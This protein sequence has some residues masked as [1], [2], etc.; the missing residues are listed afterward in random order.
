VLVVDDN[1][2]GAEMLAMF[3][4]L[5][6][7]VART[8]F[9]GKSAIAVARE[10]Q[11]EVVFLDIGLPD[12]TGYEVARAL[13]DDP[14]LSSAVLVAL[15]GWGSE[16]DKRRADEA[17]FDAHLTKPVDVAAV[18]QVLEQFSAGRIAHQP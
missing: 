13:R 12:T 17:G 2:D 15:T 14:A 10:W 6:G 16:S 9:D 3:L 11:P 4:G 7:N 8:A 18:K 1:T 5:T